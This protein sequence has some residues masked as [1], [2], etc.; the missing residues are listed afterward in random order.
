MTTQTKC[1]FCDKRG[2]PILLVRDAVAPAGEG[3]PLAPSLPIELSPTAAHY[4]KRLLRSGYVN[5]FDEARRRWEGYFLTKEGYFFKL[6]KTPDAIPPVPT[7][8]FN[9]PDEGHRAM[10]S[11]ITVSDPRNATKIWIGFSDVLWTEAI[12]KANENPNHRKRHMVE[13]DVRAAL[14]GM[15]MPHLRI[16]QASS[17]IAEYAMKPEKA[18]SAF[19]RNPFKFSVRSNHAERLIQEC[20]ALRAGGLIVTLPDPVGIVQE[21][22]FLMKRNADLFTSK[23]PENRRKLSTDIVIDGLEH[24]IRKQAQVGEITAADTLADEQV[25]ADP[26]GHWMSKNTRMKTESLRTKSSAELHHAS[27]EVWAKYAAKFD[28][29]ERVAW[30]KEFR[31]KLVDFDAKYIAPLA[32]SHVLWMKSAE[33]AAYFECNFDDFDPHVGAVYTATVA[34]CMMA[35]QDKASCSSLY[36]TWLNGDVTDTKNLL[37]RAMVF[38]QKIVA[39]KIKEATAISKDPRQIPWD[40]LFAIYAESVGKIREGIQDAAA[41]LLTQTTT[42]LAEA[43][44][45]IMDGSPGFRAALIA[46]GLFSGHPI[47]LCEV[48]GTRRE[49]QEYLIRQLQYANGRPASQKQLRVSVD[50]EMRR[51]QIHGVSMEGTTKQK[52][53][54]AIDKEM[55]TNVPR[56]MSRRQQIDQ[57]A[58]S[59][60]TMGEIE[61]L[62]LERWRTVINQNVRL[63]L[64]AGILQFVSLSKLMSDEEKALSHDKADAANRRY[65]GIAAISATI[66]DIIGNAI[67]GRASLGLRYGQGITSFAE[68]LKILGKGL[69]VATGLFVVGLDLYAGYKEFKEGSNGLVILAYAASGVAGIGLTIALIVGASIPIFALLIIVII[70]IGILI[71]FVKDN[72]IQDWLER[73]S[74]GKLKD[75]RYPN[76]AVEQAQ[77]EKAIS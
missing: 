1:E 58:K 36:E 39:E 44:S 6:L 43:F 11:C 13:I 47:I 55:A 76:L 34:H 24:A 65:A 74:W 72:P 33:L 29:D 52:F 7:K 26:L 35:T 37:L 19:A 63:G 46:A 3:A 64:I 5:V 49:V 40:N 10:A 57:L 66:S 45:K 9:C 70:G 73:C 14:K 17:I 38:N 42:S 32:S 30:Q 67:A 60:K 18:M 53:I 21:L 50:L 48:I 28:P 22:A 41:Q 16:A 27:D 56:D 31:N 77:F 69:G 8:P 25:A 15:S 68:A 59:L 12:R 20:N 23:N 75:Q 61:K 54:I 4:T 62:N 71:A 2:L 51:R